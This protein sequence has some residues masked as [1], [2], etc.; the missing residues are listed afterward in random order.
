MTDIMTR[1]ELD[2]IAHEEAI[3]SGAPTTCHW[4]VKVPSRNPEPDSLSD[5]FVIVECGAAVTYD[6]G[7]FTCESGHDHR[8]Y[9]GPDHTEYFDIDERY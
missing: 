9:G 5:C 7:G 6:H 1:G 4:L 3:A 8:T 2:R